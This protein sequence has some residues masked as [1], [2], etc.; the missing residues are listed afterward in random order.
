MPFLF[1][2]FSFSLCI[3]CII[4]KFFF[5]VI[6]RYIFKWTLWAIETTNLN[7]WRSK[8]AQCRTCIHI[9]L[10][11]T[12][13][14]IRV[15]YTNRFEIYWVH[16][17]TSNRKQTWANIMWHWWSITKCVHW[18]SNQ[19]IQIM[20]IGLNCFGSFWGD[21]ASAI[22]SSKTLICLTELKIALVEWTK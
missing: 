8:R 13:S 12:M 17:C 14:W 9:F 19:G 1:L 7:P 20:D 15:F 18:W 6:L 16:S 4:L 11:F 2:L 21:F 3:I 5:P 10:S 22:D